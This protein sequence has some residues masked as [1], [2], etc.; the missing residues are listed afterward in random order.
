MARADV[1]GTRTLI[2]RLIVKSPVTGAVLKRYI[3]PG[4]SAT[5]DPGDPAMVIASSGS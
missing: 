1:E 3:E 2:E 5:P 4:R